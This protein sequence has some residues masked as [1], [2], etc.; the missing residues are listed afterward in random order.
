MARKLVTDDR[1]KLRA[2]AQARFALGPRQDE[3]RPPTAALHEQLQV[4]QI[5][6]EMQNEELRRNQFEIEEAHE[7]FVDLY[8][9]APVGYLTVVGSGVITEANLPSASLLGEVRGNLLGRQFAAFVAPRDGDRWHTGLRDALASDSPL[10]LELAIQREDGSGFSGRLDLLRV[11]GPAGPRV[12]VT[13]STS[14]AL[15]TAIFNS[16]HFSSIATDARGVIQ[17]FN[18]GAERMLGYAATEVVNRLSPADLSDSQELVDRARKLSVEFSA[19]IA[20]GFEALVF[21]AARGI[22]DIYE[23]TYVRKDGSRLPAEVSVTALR[24]AQL[25]IVGYLLIG[26]DNTARQLARA[27]RD[28]LRARRHG[29]AGGRRRPRD[30]QSP[31]GGARRPGSSARGREGDPEAAP[32]ERTPRPAR[33]GS[34]PRRRGRRLG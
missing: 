1:Q 10:P 32:G 22:E 14:G 24:N 9:F 29:D 21:K 33:H 4:H 23:L 26:T 7:R 6:L 19:S 16:V 30:Q 18:V 12:R 13:L 11:V 20:A 28:I 27:E 3:S 15:Q 34:Q 5:E 8:D 31:G 2:D 25:G 17:I